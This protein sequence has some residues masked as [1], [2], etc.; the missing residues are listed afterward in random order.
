MDGF[1][2]IYIFL[3]LIVIGLPLAASLFI[4]WLVKKANW[5]RKYKWLALAPPLIMAFLIFRAFFPGEDFYKDDF[6]EVTGLVLPE[7]SNVKYKY[8]SFPDHFG[9]Y[10]S[11]SVIELDEEFYDELYNHLISN[12]F[13]EN[14]SPIWNDGLEEAFELLNGEKNVK[15]YTGEYQGGLYFYVG[16]SND[17]K[18][19]LVERASW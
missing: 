14:N 7:D 19:I 16:F 15:G 10:T 4:I 11:I 18:T 17:N 2:L 6:E 3:I 1:V 9:D 12:G 8:A 13:K 5:N